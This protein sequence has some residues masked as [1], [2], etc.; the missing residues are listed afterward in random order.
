MSVKVTLEYATIDEAITAMAKLRGADSKPEAAKA[1]AAPKPAAGAKDKK[2][3]AAAAPAP[4][5]S[6]P[7][8]DAPA[9]PPSAS[10]SQVGYGIVADKI[11]MGAKTHRAEVVALLGKFGAKNGKELKAEQYADFVAEIDEITKPS[12]ELA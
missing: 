11:A 3:E 7:K 5:A 6:A 4:T 2:A 1:D 9:T 8:A 10:T 12:E